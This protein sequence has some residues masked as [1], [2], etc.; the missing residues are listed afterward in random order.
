VRSAHKQLIMFYSVFSA[1]VTSA[2]SIDAPYHSLLILHFPFLTRPPQRTGTTSM[3]QDALNFPRLMF[4]TFSHLLFDALGGG[5][6]MAGQSLQRLIFGGLH[7][8]LR[9][10]PV[11]A[12]VGLHRL[13]WTLPVDVFLVDKTSQ[14]RRWILLLHHQ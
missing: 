7:R 2:T 5:I 6:R 12:L 3:L 10:L 14:Q 1:T 11:N 4:H 9:T 13:L 8:L